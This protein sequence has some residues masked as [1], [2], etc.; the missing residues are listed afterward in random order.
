MERDG[1][2]QVW[3][4]DPSTSTLVARTVQV[5]TRTGSKVRISGE[6]H[7]GEKVVTAGVNG[8]QSGQKIRMQ[9]EVS[10]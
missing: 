1:L 5:L 4:I 2:S 3:V 10:L 7:E 6:L 8:M 9:R